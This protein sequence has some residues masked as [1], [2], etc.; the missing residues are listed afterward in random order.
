MA[1]ARGLLAGCGECLWL[2]GVGCW[3]IVLIF[4]VFV[5]ML[6]YCVVA[7]HIIDVRV[8]VDNRR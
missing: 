4:C 3:W 6:T 7:I 2:W 1:S 8:V 5:V